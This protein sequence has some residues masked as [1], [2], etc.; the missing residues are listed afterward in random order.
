[1]KRIIRQTG[2][3]TAI[4]LTVSP[5]RS[6]HLHEIRLHL[7]AVGG[8]GSNEL[9]VVY[10]SDAGSEYYTLLLEQDMTAVQDLLWIPTAPIFFAA[11]D[12]LHVE[13]DNADDTE[14]GLEVVISSL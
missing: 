12:I 13:W 7:D 3:A 4:D 1:M 6:W 2:A 9:T 10:V 14:F 8:A 5:G 11:D